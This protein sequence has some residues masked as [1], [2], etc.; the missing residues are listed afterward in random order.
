MNAVANGITFA[1]SENSSTALGAAGN[2]IGYAGTNTSSQ[3]IA[4]SIAAAVDE[5][6]DQ[7]Q[8]GVNGYWVQSSNTGLATNTSSAPFI[9]ASPS[10]Q[11]TISYA[12]NA[13]AGTGALT[14]TV[15]S[16]SNG[17]SYSMVTNNIDLAAALGGT[18]GGTASAYF[19]FTGGTG[20]VSD[21]QS[22]SN[23]SLNTT[24][25]NQAL[26]AVNIA[27][28]ISVNASST[29]ILQLAP[30]AGNSYGSVGPITI[31]TGSTLT[32][33]IGSAPAAG[34]LRGVLATPS[35]TFANSSSGTLDIK[36]NALDITT[37]SQASIVQAE[38]AS[39]YAG[40][41]WNGSGITSSVA[42]TDTS[43]LTAVGMLINNDGHGNTIYGVPTGTG[44]NLGLFDGASPSLNDI[45]VKYTYYGDANLDGAVDGSD[46]AL[47]DAGFLSGGALIGWQNG[48]FNYDGVVD[49]SDYTLID[50]TFNTQGATLGVN[51]NALAASSAAQFGGSSAVPE[52]ASFG[53]LLM[54]SSLLVRRRYRQ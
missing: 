17:S 24:S 5:Y 51:P 1:L 11:V 22:I 28:A 33:S 21:A 2:A 47:I 39:A 48:D 41:A 15:T 10:S 18:A 27:N 20:A 52:P 26:S 32:V 38:I 49:G 42:A 14:E 53:V 30:T 31:N 23:F 12:Y 46:Y 35:V 25:T 19:G 37:A 29:A 4:N 43:H 9:S 50:N 36:N 44:P 6:D 45:L 7:L 8:T 16:L 40:G 54:G 13:S 3:G 34:V